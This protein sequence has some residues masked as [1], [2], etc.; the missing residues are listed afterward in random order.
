MQIVNHKLTAGSGV[1]PY[2]EAANIDEL[3]TPRVIVLHDT[4][5]GIAFGSAANFLAQSPKVSVHFVIERNGAIQQLAPTNRACD[6]A[7][8][9][10]YHG[11]DGVNAFSIGIELVNPGRMDAAQ[12][13]F[14]RAW[15]DKVFPNADCGIVW[16][17]TPEHGAGWWMPHTAPQ[18]EALVGLCDVL[19]RDVPTIEDIRGHWYVSP[20]RKTDPGPTLNVEAIRSVVLGRT[21]PVD[22]ALVR[23][24]YVPGEATDLVVSGGYADRVRTDTPGDTLNM[25]RWP[26]FNPNVIGTIP[27][28]TELTVIRH[29]IFGDREWELVSYGGREGWVTSDYTVPV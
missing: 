20:G 3:M 26:S 29:G 14:S 7:G 2:R 21:D 10:H 6:H 12:P 18:I 11:E 28:G 8:A 23:D 9:S 13:G 24:S 5:S 1:M 17:E 19:V 4:A 16:A 15:F 22:A 25:R 27:N